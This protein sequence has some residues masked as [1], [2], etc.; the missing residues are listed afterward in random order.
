MKKI[1]L[2][3][4]TVALAA[5][6]TMADT[7]EFDFAN[8]DYG[9][10]RL[11]G[12][13][14]NYLPSPTTI[15]NGDATIVISKKD[16]SNGW[17]LW[18]DGLRVY[19][20]S[21]ATLTI[22]VANSTISKV[23]IENASSIGGSVSVNGTSQDI[24]G[25]SATFDFNNVPEAELVFTPANNKAITKL[26]ITYAAALVGDQQAAG[27]SFDTNA[28]TIPQGNG[29][30]APTL[31]NPN[32][33]AV[34]W[35]SSNEEV[36]TV[37]AN[38]TVTLA[39][40]TGS[41]KIS[42]SWAGNAQFAEGTASYTLTVVANSTSIADLMEICTAANDQ[43][44]ISFPMT[45]V[46]VNGSNCYVVDEAGNA[47]LLYQNTN[48]EEGDVIPAGWTAIYSPY[49]GLPEF[50]MS[51]VP[52]STEKAP[53]TIAEVSTVGEDDVNKV[54]VLKG[55]TFEEATPARTDENKAANFYGTLTD[56]TQMLFRTNFNIDS[57]EA[58]K[59]D[60]KL[61]VCIY[62]GT[63]QLYPIEYKEST[64]SGV[65]AIEADGVAEYYNL[66]GVKVAQPENGIFV[67]V[68]NGK[69]TKVVK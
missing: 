29:F 1:L 60:V 7:V 65:A 18:T 14:S 33:L 30:T 43:A 62:N 61:A 37:D 58:G 32:N 59:Y 16:G 10:E 12:S 23:E 34:S 56:G 27:L 46:Y 36:A 41:T 11:S 20:N 13:A 63:L 31:N 47:T 21:D 40:A 57:V 51:E 19:K 17:R 48:Y 26:T 8:N 52:E 38:G 22:T 35:S 66:Q 28:V 6:A 45:A 39:G 5:S 69:A 54:V 42:A 15:T 49:Y 9:M 3:L 44:Y 25:T 50:K 53:V 55:V 2:S 68:V 67:K 24:S 64:Q 4:A